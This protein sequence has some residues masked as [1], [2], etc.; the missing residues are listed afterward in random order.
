[1]STGIRRNRLFAPT[2]IVAVALLIG[3]M[4]VGLGQRVSIAQEMTPHPGHI[5]TGPCAELGGVVFPLDPAGGGMIMGTAVAGEMMGPESAIPVVSSVTTVAADLATIISGGHAI[6]FHASEADMGAYIACGDIGGM[7]MGS[8]LAIG[9]AELN[10]SGYTGVAWLHDNGDGT[11]TVAV[12][13]TQDGGEADADADADAA[14]PAATSGDT[15]DA[16]EVAVEIAE[17]TFSPDPVEVAVGTTVT[18]TNQD[19]EPHTAT[20]DGGS[21]TTE[22]INPGES[23]SVTFDTAGEFPYFCEFHPNMAGTVVVQ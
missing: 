5:H 9:L 15:A 4:M 7:V 1:M 21:F 10:D 6:N 12:F 23:D 17:F 19:S 2:A 8:D 16:G 20:G 3:A 13:L 11:T 18:W 14:T 22:T